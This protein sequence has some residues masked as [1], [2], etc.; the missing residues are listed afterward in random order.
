[1]FIIIFLYIVVIECLF[2]PLFKFSIA[3][4]TQS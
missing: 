2:Y 4:G 1:M 3:Y